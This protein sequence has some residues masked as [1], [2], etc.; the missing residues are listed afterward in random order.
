MGRGQVDTRAGNLRDRLTAQRQ[1]GQ[2]SKRSLCGLC[3]FSTSA[4]VKPSCRDTRSRAR[5]SESELATDLVAH[6]IAAAGAVVVVPIGVIYDLAD[7]SDI[8]EQGV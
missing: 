5:H 3:R 2:L 6:Q 4:H 7:A 8:T 1:G